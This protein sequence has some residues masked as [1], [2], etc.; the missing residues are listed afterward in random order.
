MAITNT[1][2]NQQKHQNAVTII[3]WTV[4]TPHKLTFP[5]YF[6]SEVLMF[7]LLTP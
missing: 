5:S 1:Y 2:D 3:I 6:L 4:S 7:I